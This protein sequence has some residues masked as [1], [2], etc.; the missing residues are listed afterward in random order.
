ME[1]EK[2]RQQLVDHY[3]DFYTLAYSMLS[4]DDDARDAV[5][6]ALARTM[7]K[8]WL[9]DPMNYCY[10][11]LR[12]AAIDTLRHRYRMAP[13]TAD[14]AD[15]IADEEADNE[16]ATLLEH[17]AH[18]RD[19]LPQATRA[20]VVLHDERGLGYHELATLTGM[21]VMTIRRRLNEAHILLRHKLTKK[22]GENR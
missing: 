17:A 3:L 21:S 14:I 19:K 5:Q 18:L 16:Y 22:K 8:P 13:F 9:G 12:R 6:E 10:Q 15:E 11:T 2:I 20:L 1:R 7:S 4:N